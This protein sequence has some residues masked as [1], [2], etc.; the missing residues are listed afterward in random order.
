[1]FKATRP[2]VLASLVSSFIQ[3]ACGFLWAFGPPGTGMGFS[4]L[5]AVALAVPVAAL[6]AGFVGAGWKGRTMGQP[7]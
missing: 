2:G 7:V 5:T 3:A 1:M 4:L 6:L